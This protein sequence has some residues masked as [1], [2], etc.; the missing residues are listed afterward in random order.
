[1][2]ARRKWTRCYRTIRLGWG[3]SPPYHDSNKEG[4]ESD[5]QGYKRNILHVRPRN[6]VMKSKDTSGMCCFVLSFLK[7]SEEA[8]AC[9]VYIMLWHHAVWHHAHGFELTFDMS[10]RAPAVCPL[11]R[12]EAQNKIEKRRIAQRK[13]FK[14]PEEEEK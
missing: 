7:V 2:H 12:T 5:L 6:V 11:F 3:F 13:N 10:C 1:M 4:A 14:A 9:H 8:C